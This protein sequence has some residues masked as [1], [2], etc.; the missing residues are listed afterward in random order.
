MK[1]LF[2]KLILFK[3]LKNISDFEKYLFNRNEQR[4]KVPRVF[5]EFSTKKILTMERLYGIPLTNLNDIKK[6]SKD[7]RETL[8]TALSIWFESLGN[9]DVFHADVHA[10]NLLLLRDGRI[11]FID[12]GIVGRISK[13]VWQGLLFFMQGIGSENPTLMAKGLKNDGFNIKRNQ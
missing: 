11:G 12:F 10:G 7:P 13:Q 6:Y 8:T 2:R 1:T 4:A 3:K 9:S 5:H